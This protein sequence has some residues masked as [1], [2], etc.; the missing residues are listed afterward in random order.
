MT[1]M[2]AEALAR[3]L[4]ANDGAPPE[5]LLGAAAILVAAALAKLDLT[6]DPCPDCG[7]PFYRNME[8]YRVFTRF[9]ELPGRLKTGA[10]RLE[11][12]GTYPTACGCVKA[13]S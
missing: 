10:G 11:R 1:R 12:P 2:H 8:H 9:H 5:G 4:A 13:L 6:S 3:A 7:R